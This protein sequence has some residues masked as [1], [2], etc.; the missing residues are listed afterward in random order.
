MV[1]MVRARQNLARLGA[2]AAATFALACGETAERPP[3]EIDCTADDGYDLKPI[4]TW[5][6][7][8]SPMFSA[9]ASGTTPRSITSWSASEP[10]PTDACGTSPALHVMMFNNPDW[11]S[12]VGTYQ[13][14]P[15][16]ERDASG[17]SGISF[18]AKATYDKFFTLILSDSQSDEASTRPVEEGGCDPNANIDERGVSRPEECGNLFQAIFM[19]TEWWQFYTI[20]WNQFVQEER[21]N[22]RNGGIDSSAIY[23]IIIRS[24]KDT[25]TDL[26]MD[27]FA[28]YRKKPAN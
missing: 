24:P 22:L 14:L 3:R 10:Y 4:P 25:A 6:S 18:W 13:R 2:L 9:P 26:W 11:G 28:W 1:T 16:A 15:E 20:P 23:N 17:Y 7:P 8:T 12:I 19:V 5:E 27:D 21:P